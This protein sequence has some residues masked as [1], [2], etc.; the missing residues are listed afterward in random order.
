MPEEPPMNI[1]YFAYEVDTHDSSKVASIL[2]NKGVLPGEVTEEQYFDLQVNILRDLIRLRV[3]PQ[4]DELDQTLRDATLPIF[5]AP[6]FFFKYEGGK[7]YSRATVFNRIE[8]YLKPISEAF[9][10]VLIVAG[11]IWWGEPAGDG[12]LTVHNTLP[13][14]Y[15]GRLVHTWRKTRLSP[16]DGLDKGAQVWD[17]WEADNERILDATQTPFL[18]LDLPGGPLALGLEICLDHFTLRDARNQLTARGVLRT[19]YLEAHA[20][21]DEG[22]GVD[23]HILVAAG[24]PTQPENIVARDNGLFL[25]CDGGKGAERSSCLDITRDGGSAASALRLWSPRRANVI[26]QYLPGAQNQANDADDRVAAYGPIE[27]LDL[28]R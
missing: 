16:I 7:P 17:R 21:A 11:T 9:P 5:V 10:R 18:T 14:L 4:V 6:E 24:M 27:L 15:N 8:G 3:Q 13:V 23:V 20:A 22:P 12:K 28:P 25:R 1:F 2:K 26:A 19:E